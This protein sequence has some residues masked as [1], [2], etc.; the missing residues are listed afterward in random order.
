MPDGG[1]HQPA[2]IPRA[3][4]ARMAAYYLSLSV[5]TFRDQV[6]PTVPPVQLT[7][8][9]LAWLRE[10]LDRWLDARRGSV[11]PSEDVDPFMT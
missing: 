1:R 7:P 5:T 3:L 6:V 4:S 11:P 10:D 9:R 2:W 8:G